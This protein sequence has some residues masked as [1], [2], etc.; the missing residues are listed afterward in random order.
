MIGTVVAVVRGMRAPGRPAPTAAPILGHCPTCQ[1][2]PRMG[3][4]RRSGWRCSV[5]WEVHSWN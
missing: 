5:C 1:G 4:W 3:T 2:T